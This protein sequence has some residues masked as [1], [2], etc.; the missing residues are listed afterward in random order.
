LLKKSIL[1]FIEKVCEVTLE[2]GKEVGFESRTSCHG[3]QEIRK[4]NEE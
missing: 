4:L 2:R 1:L 3:S